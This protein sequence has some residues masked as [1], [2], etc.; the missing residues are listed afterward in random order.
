MGGPVW[1]Y[2]FS[3]LRPG[4]YIWAAVNFNNVPHLKSLFCATSELHSL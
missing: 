4:M 3:L 2:G 1:V